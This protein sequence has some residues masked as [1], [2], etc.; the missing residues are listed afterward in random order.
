MTLRVK[1]GMLG[2]VRSLKNEITRIDPYGR[3]NMIEPG[4][5]ATH[6]ARPALQDPKQVSQAVRRDPLIQRFRQS[7]EA[8]SWGDPLDEANR[9]GPMAR[10][11]LREEL[12]RQVTDSIEQG[13]VAVTG[14]EIPPGE[15]AFYPPSIL[16]R[17]VPGVRAWREE[18]FGPVA[19][20]IGAP[21]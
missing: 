21:A 20:C 16:D 2:L 4:W 7:V 6:M 11:D 10:A 5:T 3:V 17:V 13:A 1:A 12:H 14:C 8:L 9:L 19:A 15:G 18:L